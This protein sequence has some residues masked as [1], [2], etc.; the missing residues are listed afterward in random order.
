MDIK[1]IEQ[2][3]ILAHS[4]EVYEYVN[5]LKKYDDYILPTSYKGLLILYSSKIQYILYPDKNPDNTI[6]WIFLNGDKAIIISQHLLS[7]YRKRILDKV[8]DMKYNIRCNILDNLLLLVQLVSN[9]Q[10]HIVKGVGI[11]SKYNDSMFAWCEDGL[12]PIE[13]LSDIVYRCITFIPINMLRD[14][15]L[16]NW[17]SIY[18]TLLE[19]KALD[20]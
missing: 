12:I 5:S 15:Q 19:N 2:L 1:D 9:I 16:E 3:Y 14:Y 17:K 20:K 8:S 13:E 4:K 11:S 7:R 10:L 18:S 6:D